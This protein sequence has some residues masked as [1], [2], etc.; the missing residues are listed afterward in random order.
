[1]GVICKIYMSKNSFGVWQAPEELPEIVNGKGFSNIQVAVGNESKKNDEV[2]Y[3]VSNRPGGQGGLD[4]WF[5]IFMP[6]KNEWR[7]PKNC[8]NKMNTA[9]DEMSPYYDVVS[10]TMYY[11][12][13]GHAGLGEFDIFKTNGELGKWTPAENMGYP[14][15]SPY[16]DYYLYLLLM[17]NQEFRLKSSRWRLVAGHETCCDD[18]YEV[19]FENVFEIPVT[20]RVFEVE[21]KEIKKLINKNFQQKVWKLKK[22]P[23]KFVLFPGSTVSLFMAYQ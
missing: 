21:D 2:L 17:Q 12:S 4:I 7:E 20:G 9:G 23:M 16:D 5:T 15:N 8:G 1:M 14:I 18:L 3:F 6:K 10:R 22:I 11:S 19:I 13:T